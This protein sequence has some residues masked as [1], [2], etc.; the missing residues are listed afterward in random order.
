MK[1]LR[2]AALFASIAWITVFACPHASPAQATAPATE[3]ATQPASV[4]A[5]AQA[6]LDELRDAYAKLT[7]L[8]VAGTLSLELDIAGQRQS[9]RSEFTGGFVAPNRFRHEMSDDALVVGNGA[10]A[11]LYVAKTGK[12]AESDAP[13]ARAPSAGLD[14]SVAQVLRA[15]NPSLYL[16]LCASAADELSDGAT[17]VA[18]LD[19][20]RVNDMDCDVLRIETEEHDARVM[21]APST[22]LVRRMTFDLGKSVAARGVPDVKRAMITIDYT[23]TKPDATLA[24]DRFAWTP[25][26][27]A[28]LARDVQVA[29]AGEGAAEAMQGKAGPDFT[30]RDLDDNSVSLRSLRGSVVVLDFWATWCGPCRA[31]LPKLDALHQEISADGVR[32]FA[33]NLRE[34]KAT[35][36]KFVDATGLKLPVLLD[37]SGSVGQK[38]AVSGIP[39]TVVIDRKGVIR[40]VFVGFSPDTEAKLR[41]AIR[42][43]NAVR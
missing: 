22:R 9:K 19:R 30:L 14:G 27:D 26:A 4:P 21:I 39:Q 1:Y 38:Y 24:D 37:E 34:D 41:E 20:A 7:G 15:Q 11:F 23:T 32:V 8:E 31:S 10:K 5:D 40:R 25:P 16:A 35:A 42:E 28:T 17:S 43:A 33:V 12:Y 2:P 18:K 13:E 6:L 36:Q 3:P 29:A